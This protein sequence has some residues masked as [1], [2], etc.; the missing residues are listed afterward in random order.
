M[1]VPIEGGCLCGSVRYALYGPLG[2]IGFCHCRTC[3]KAEG[4]AFAATARI[5]REDVVWL[6]GGSTLRSYESTPGKQR[7]FCGTCGAKLFAAWDGDDELIL[8]LGSL[9]GD[10]GSRPVVHIWTG[11]R[12]AWLD[13]ETTLPTLQRGVVDE[14]SSDG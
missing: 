13:L 6:S 10:P 1:S 4:V 11:E 12:A 7:H 3:R 14:R 2:P 5:A 9:D 8:R